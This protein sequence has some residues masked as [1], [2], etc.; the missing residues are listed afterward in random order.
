[1]DKKQ[2]KVKPKKENKKECLECGGKLNEEG[3]EC[4]ECGTEVHTE[5]KEPEMVKHEEVSLDGWDEYDEDEN[6]E[7]GLY[8]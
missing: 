4:I 3:T 6:E 8:S 7:D 2:K 5:D 1:M